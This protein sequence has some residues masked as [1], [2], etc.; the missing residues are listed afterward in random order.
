MTMAFIKQADYLKK[1]NWLHAFL[2]NNKKIP[3][4]YEYA[5]KTSSMKLASAPVRTKDEIEPSSIIGQASNIHQDGDNIVCDVELLPLNTLS[6]HFTGVIDNYVIKV[7]GRNKDGEPNYDIVRFIVYDK[8]FK[9][10][11][12]ES[13]AKRI[14][15][16]AEQQ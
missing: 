12:D 7:I 9:R 1:R 14:Q 13:Y 4:V 5:Q 16:S 3:I 11:V 6:E 2:S 10:K 8:N 15:E